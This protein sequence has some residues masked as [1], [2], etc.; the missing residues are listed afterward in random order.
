[1]ELK[2]MYEKIISEKNNKEEKKNFF[3]NDFK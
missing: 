2:K 3:F 1:M